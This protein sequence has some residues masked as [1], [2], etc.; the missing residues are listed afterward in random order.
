MH[1]EECHFSKADRYLFDSGAHSYAQGWAQV[2]S[3]QD[4]SYFGTWTN[5]DTLQIAEYI[6]GD[7]RLTTYDTAEEYVAG[8]R[9]FAEYGYQID[10]GWPGGEFAEKFRALG[11]GEMLH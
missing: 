2:D 1:V 6:E 5:P 11:L 7:Y 10:P 9:G 8:M 3:R 4:A